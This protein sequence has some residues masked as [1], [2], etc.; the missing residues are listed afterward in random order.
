[1]K[2]TALL[3]LAFLSGFAHSN[4]SLIPL[5]APVGVRPCCAFG[6]DLKAQVG[7]VPVPFF[8]LENVLNANDIGTHQYNDGSESIS[9]S[10]LG[11]GEEVN[12]LLFTKDG[13]FIDTAH[14]RDTADYTYYLFQLNRKNL[15][16]AN[17]IDLPT[18]LR[19][20]RITW[21]KHSTVL[22]EK[23]RIQRSA[24]A[25]AL[26]AFRLAQWHEIG[27]WFGMVSVSG[28]KELASAFSSEDLYS[29]M[30]GATLAR[31][32]LLAN[33]EIDQISFSRAMD[34][35]FQQILSML[36]VQPKSI[37]REKIQQLDGI[38]WDSSKR[39]PDKWVV[40]FRDYHL[41]LNLVP[42]YS[43][44]TKQLSLTDRFTDQEPIEQWVSLSLV[45]EKM[46]N[47]F[48]SLPTELKNRTTW[49]PSDFQTLADFAKLHDAQHNPL[50]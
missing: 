23:E 25:A 49:Q 24:D 6:V 15:G 14:V 5:K 30:L 37:T 2:K 46:E 29:N 1:M 27:Q 11:L 19:I 21:H 36:N 48:N 31:T 40:I 39:L 45:A 38:W 17:T 50:N 12:G 22:S 7:R 20:R 32:I 42:N 41:A 10:L 35:A 8:S 28:F 33:P 16:N 18:E 26:M 4:T 13:G 3:L 34:G 44:S 9:G 43:G 47:H